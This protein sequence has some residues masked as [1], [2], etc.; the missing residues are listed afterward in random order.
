MSIS[1]ERLPHFV[2]VAGVPFPEMVTRSV[3]RNGSGHGRAVIDGG[4][5]GRLSLS[6]SRDID[7]A[8]SRCSGER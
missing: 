1:A 7:A 6:G 3:I 5:R 8:A 2:I 4:E